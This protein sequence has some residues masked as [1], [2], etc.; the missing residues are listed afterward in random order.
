[1][2]RQYFPERDHSYDQEIVTQ[3]LLNAVPSTY[4][5]YS[6]AILLLRKKNPDAKLLGVDLDETTGELSITS[7]QLLTEVVGERDMYLK[8]YW[9]TNTYEFNPSI[10]I[11]PFLTEEDNVA[12]TVTIGSRN[13]GSPGTNPRALA[14]GYDF[15]TLELQPE[16]NEI[17]M[18]SK[19]TKLHYDKAGTL[20]LVLDILSRS[21]PPISSQ[22]KA[23]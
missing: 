22:Q 12:Y 8:H 5:D 20:G 14:M 7:P 11:K 1:M 4:T 19:L 16:T 17:S 3:E 15:L 23:S 2:D 6:D 13:V 21:F 18:S 9:H 10:A